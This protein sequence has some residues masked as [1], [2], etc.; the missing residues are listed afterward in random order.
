M[1]VCNGRRH[2][3]G[4]FVYRGTEQLTGFTVADLRGSALA[5]GKGRA[6]AAYATF[7]V[8]LT[9][10]TSCKLMIWSAVVETS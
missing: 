10:T 2:V 1:Y 6:N 9:I 5:T 4:P 7:F 8:A 3:E